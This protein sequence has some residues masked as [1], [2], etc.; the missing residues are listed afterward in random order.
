M[1]RRSSSRGI[2]DRRCSTAASKLHRGRRRSDPAVGTSRPVTLAR[3]QK[4]RLLLV[5][6]GWLWEVSTTGLP[7]GIF[8]LRNALIDERDAGELDGYPANS[9]RRFIQILLLPHDGHQ[10]ARTSKGFARQSKSLS[11]PCGGLI[12]VTR[13]IVVRES[14]YADPMA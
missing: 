7:D 1:R 9:R 6:E 8:E 14:T 3:T 12:R 13:Q 4:I 11:R 5:V 10:T 2:R